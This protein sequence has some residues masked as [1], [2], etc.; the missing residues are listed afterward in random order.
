MCL[1]LLHQVKLERCQRRILIHS[2]GEAKRLLRLFK[3]VFALDGLQ[4]ASSYFR[5]GAIDVE[6]W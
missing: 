6:R 5:L 2:D 4:A 1:R 3:N